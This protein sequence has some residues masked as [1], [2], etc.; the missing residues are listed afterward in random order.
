[1]HTLAEQACPPL[2]TTPHAPQLLGSDV[3]SAHEPLH[4]VRPLAHT[5][6]SGGIAVLPRTFTVTT[7]CGL[8]A[9][10]APTVLLPYQES[11]YCPGGSC[12]RCISALFVVSPQVVAVQV[13]P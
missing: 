13:C 12:T 9:L 8:C 2:Q 3:R 5:P 6:A 1:M 7:V 4:S 11:K 10:M